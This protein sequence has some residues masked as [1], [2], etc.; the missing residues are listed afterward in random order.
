MVLKSHGKQ[1]HNIKPKKSNKSEDFVEEIQKI[2]DEHPRLYEALAED[3][4]DY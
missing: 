4:F 1:D 3:K 2:I